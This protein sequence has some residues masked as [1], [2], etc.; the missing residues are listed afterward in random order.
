MTIVTDFRYLDDLHLVRFRS[1]DGRLFMLSHEYR[2]SFRLDGIEAVYTVPAGTKTDL[3]SIPRF[4]PRAIAEK[5]DKHI[6]S[7]VVHDR[8]CQDLGPWDSVTAAKIFNE[9]MRAAR[10]PAWRRNVMYRAV[11]YFGPK[12]A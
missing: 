1:G 5:V 10:V 12:W 8:Q 6:E 11:L 4:V 3:A 2:V 7:A 9:G